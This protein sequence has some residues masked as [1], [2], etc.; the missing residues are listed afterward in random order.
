MKGGA[1]GGRSKDRGPACVC[2]QE[3]CEPSV[4]GTVD[5]Q[6]ARAQVSED[7]VLGCGEGRTS[8]LS[9]TRSHC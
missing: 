1:S 6:V 3:A 8:S 9:V 5:G 2:D 4:Q 7:L